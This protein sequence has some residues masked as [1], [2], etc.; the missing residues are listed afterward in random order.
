MTDS[1][2]RAT[3]RCI[4]QQYER[5]VMEMGMHDF[6]VSAYVTDNPAQE[7]TKYKANFNFLMT[8]NDGGGGGSYMSMDSNGFAYCMTN[9]SNCRYDPPSGATPHEMGHVWE[10]TAGGFNG[11]DSSGAWWECT[12]NWMMLQFDNTYPQP[13]AYDRQRHVLSRPRQ[14]LL[15]FMT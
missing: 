11:T 5:I 7:V 9:S 10:G 3:C 14:G 8:W 15:R 13:G 4:E 12:A 1:L 2:P 6:N